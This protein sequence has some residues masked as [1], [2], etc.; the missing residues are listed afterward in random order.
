MVVTIWSLSDPVVQWS[1]GLLV[2]VASFR[3][4]RWILSVWPG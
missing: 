3:L 4:I 1:L 2:A